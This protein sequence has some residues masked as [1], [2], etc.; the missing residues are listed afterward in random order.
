MVP[1][2]GAQFPSVPFPY[3]QGACEVVDVVAGAGL[4]VVVGACVVVVAGAQLPSAFAPYSHAGGLVFFGGDF[5]VVV[6]TC[7]GGKHSCPYS[8]S[9][10][11]AGW[12]GSGGGG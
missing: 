8:H 3:W 4:V 10:P 6:D 2:G 11:G 5:D 9:V 7:V 12:V 1:G